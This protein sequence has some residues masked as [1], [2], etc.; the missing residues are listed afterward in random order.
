ME[1]LSTE[2]EYSARRWR[3]GDL[4]PG[5]LTPVPAYLTGMLGCPFLLR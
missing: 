2:P 4:N 3:R 1:R 5:R